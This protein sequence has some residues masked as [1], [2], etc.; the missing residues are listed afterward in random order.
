MAALPDANDPE[1]GPKIINPQKTGSTPP[2]V[3]R[4][5]YARDPSSSTPTLT[6]QKLALLRFLGEC[7]LLSLPQLARLCC[8]SEQSA[9]RH[10]RE[11]FDGGLVDI[12]AVPRAALSPAGSANDAGLLHGS[13]PNVYV[14]TKAGLEILIQLGYAERDVLRRPATD[15]G[16][17]NAL[18]LAHELAV[19]DVRVWLET[20]ALTAS[21]R[22]VLAWRDGAEAHIPLTPRYARPDAWFTYQVGWHRPLAEQAEPVPLVLV[23][24]TE[25]DRGTERGNV[26]WGEKLNDYYVVF[27]GNTLQATTGYRN[28][29]VLVFVPDVRRRDLL[30]DLLLTL[31]RDRGYPQRLAERFWLAEHEFLVHG[32]LEAAVW[33]RP[34]DKTLR[35]LLAS[36]R[37]LTEK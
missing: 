17:K 9:R 4:G 25:I 3:R 31:I 22:R 32:T 33:R 12:I 23:G 37:P 27:S 15:L 10:L 21:P 28:A 6:P 13:A 36:S 8:P 7:R 11:L 24:L 5:R 35:P 14:A 16:P 20:D 34:G 2:L 26:R 1:T 30:A 18:F 19:R 29:R